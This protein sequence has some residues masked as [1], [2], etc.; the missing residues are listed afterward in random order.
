MH[1]SAYL[2]APSKRLRNADKKDGMKKR[3]EDG[4]TSS[5]P[6]FVVESRVAQALASLHANSTKVVSETKNGM[7]TQII[8]NPEVLATLRGMFPASRTYAFQIHAYG[9]L[10][11][12]G[13]GVIQ[14]AYAVNPGVLSYSEWSALS[15]LFD[16]CRL[17]RTT[18]GLT[19]A[20]LPAN[21]AVPLWISFDHTTSTGVG[22]GYG[23]VQRLARSRCINSLYMEGGG[24]RHL[25]T[26][27]VNPMRAWSPTATPTSTIVDTGL[28]GQWDVSAQDTTGNNLPVAYYDLENVVSFRNRA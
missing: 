13:A 25:Q 7:S 6:P 9:L 21:K 2:K 1:K 3:D 26:T 17:K 24:G 8:F 15:A 14:L 18:V 4:S 19:S 27:S 28:N 10:Q 23:N 11:S 22:I 5:I 16:E 20:S 12:T